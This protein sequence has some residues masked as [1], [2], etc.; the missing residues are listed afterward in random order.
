MYQAPIL[1]I[2]HG[3]FFLGAGK[4]PFNGLLP[5][6]IQFLVLWSI[7]GVIRQ[8]LIDLPDVP[9][10]RLYAV[11]G[12]GAQVPGRTFCTDLRI[13][14]VL[15]VFLPFGGSVGQHLVLRADDAVI[16]FIISFTLQRGR[17]ALSS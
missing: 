14:P 8:F 4:D 16:M 5:L 3:V 11:Y 17:C 15:P 2:T 1:G 9:L 12:A 6:L 13:T 7:A 10:Y